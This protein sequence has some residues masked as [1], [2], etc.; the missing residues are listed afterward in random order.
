VNGQAIYRV[1]IGPIAGVDDFDR[2]VEK[3]SMIG[4]SDAYL[5]LD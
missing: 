4:I 3:M 1:R 2:V 5:A